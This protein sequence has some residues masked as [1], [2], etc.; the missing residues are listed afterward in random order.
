MSPTLLE[1]ALV[2][3]ILIVAWQIGIAIAPSVLRHLR[4]MRDELDEVADDVLDEPHT[5]HPT[6]GRTNG[7]HG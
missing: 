1:L 6:K 5:E 2:I 4:G 3:V 7:K